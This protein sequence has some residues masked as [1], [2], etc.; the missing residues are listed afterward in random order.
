MVGQPPRM[1]EE[2]LALVGLESLRDDQQP[3]VVLVSLEQ[4]FDFRSNLCSESFF[5]M[6]DF[7]QDRMGGAIPG[8]RPQ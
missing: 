5:A 4:R 3:P 6:K 7:P 1:C 8:P 2:G